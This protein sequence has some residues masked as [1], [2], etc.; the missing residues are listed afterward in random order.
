MPTWGDRPKGRIDWG[1][2]GFVALYVGAFVAIFHI[3]Y[4]IGGM[5]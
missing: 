5:R 4:L 2:L 3:G 1:L